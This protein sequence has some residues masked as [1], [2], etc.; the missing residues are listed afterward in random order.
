[1]I[2]L[3]NTLIKILVINKYFYK[4]MKLKLYFGD[5]VSLKRLH[6]PNRREYRDHN[7]DAL[8][9]TSGNAQ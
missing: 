2:F 9:G 7:P 3:Q 1:M 4:N 6:L 8:A 5:R